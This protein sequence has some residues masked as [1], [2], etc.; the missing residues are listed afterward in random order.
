[1]E[2]RTPHRLLAVVKALVEAGKV[3]VTPSALAGGAALGLDFGG[4]IGVGMALTPPGS[5]KSMTTRTDHQ[6]GCVP[7]RDGAR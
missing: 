5:H 4:M 2:T 6:A 1:M 3:R 7:P